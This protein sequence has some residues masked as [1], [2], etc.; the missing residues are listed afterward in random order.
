M[1][2]TS[3]LF[4]LHRSPPHDF[5]IDTVNMVPSVSQPGYLRGVFVVHPHQLR[6]ERTSHG[7]RLR[8]FVD[9]QLVLDAPSQKWVT[10]APA[11][12]L[13]LTLTLTLTLIPMLT[14]TGR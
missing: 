2:P 14:L 1:Y 13:T 5:T 4:P 8:V 7:A 12:N 6:D 10:L 9:T 3:N 11:P